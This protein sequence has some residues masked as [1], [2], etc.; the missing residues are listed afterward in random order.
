MHSPPEVFFPQSRLTR[1][2]SVQLLGSASFLAVVRL[3]SL[4]ATSVSGLQRGKKKTLRPLA[5]NG[6]IVLHYC[7]FPIICFKLFISLKSS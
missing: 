6:G 7:T 1:T 4:T 3:P 5:V 2:A